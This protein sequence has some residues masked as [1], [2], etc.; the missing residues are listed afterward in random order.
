MVGD[1]DVGLLQLTTGPE[2]G[3]GREVAAAAIGTLT[4]VGGQTRPV[5]VLDLQ[6]PAVAI[7]CPLA[8]GIVLGHL[9]GQLHEAAAVAGDHVALEQRH[10]RVVLDPFQRL[11]ELLHAQVTATTLGQRIVEAQPRMLL[12]RRQVLMHDLFL[13]RDGRGRDHQPLAARLGHRQRGEQIASVLPVPV[14]ASST[15]TCSLPRR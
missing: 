13:Q 12:E 5:A 14:P 8:A 6:R 9:A 7:P 4:M 11:V 1:D 2:E 15:Q 10:G 3:A